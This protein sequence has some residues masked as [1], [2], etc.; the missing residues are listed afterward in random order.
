MTLLSVNS[1]SLERGNR[2]VLSDISLEVQP[3]EVVGLIGPNGA[4][5]T[6]LMRAALGLVPATGKCSL[7]SLDARARAKSVAWMPQ[8]REV[9]WP[10]SVESL[11]MLGRLPHGGGVDTA[12]DKDRAA[13]L[14]AMEHLGL[15]PLRHRPATELSGGEKARVLLARAIAQ[16]AP[17]IMADEPTAGLDPGHQITAMKVFQELA[18]GGRSVIVS[19]H[20]LGLAVRHSTRLVL[21]SEGQLV[22]DGLPLDVLSEERLAQVFGIRAHIASTEEGPVLQTLD[23]LS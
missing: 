14:S 12:T 13:V 17:L 15:V 11:I 5:K 23:V 8:D 22:A 2:A 1:L 7:W 19:L 9:A 18:A 6:T 3:G 10:I 21:L 20:D 16:E 4:G